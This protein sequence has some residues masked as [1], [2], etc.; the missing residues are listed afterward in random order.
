MAVGT[1]VAHASTHV[2]IFAVNGV[3]VLLS[4]GASKK[5]RPEDQPPEAQL[6]RGPLLPMSSLYQETTIHEC[7]TIDL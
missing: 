2:A 5:N 7:K 1:L 3:L 4:L 6:H